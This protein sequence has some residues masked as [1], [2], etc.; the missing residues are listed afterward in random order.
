[1]WLARLTG[2]K[3]SVRMAELTAAWVA[4]MTLMKTSRQIVGYWIWLENLDVW[5]LVFGGL[6]GLVRQWV[7]RE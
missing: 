3:K 2:K 7:W 6:I 5:A 4:S 1:M